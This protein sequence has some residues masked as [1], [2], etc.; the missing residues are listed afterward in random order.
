MTLSCGTIRSPTRVI[1]EI[2]SF[3]S[4]TNPF[5]VQTDDG[6]GF[7]KATNN[8]YNGPALTAELVAA[9]LGTWFGLQI[10]AFAVIPTCDIDLPMKNGQLVQGPLF[11]S[12]EVEATSFD[13]SDLFLKKLH[14]KTDIAK[15]VVFDTWIMNWDRY[16]LGDANAENLLFA[17]RDKSRKYDLIPIDH[18]WAFD[19]DFPLALNEDDV[20]SPGVYGRFPAFEPYITSE[21]LAPALQRLRS[22]D[23]TFVKEVINSV[24]SEWGVGPVARTTLIELICSRAAFVVNTIEE[25]LIDAPLLPGVN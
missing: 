18:T 3:P 14:D 12:A 7:I 4:S 22:L 25:R 5:F 2:K 10:P 16:G 8:P 15:L 11:F 6:R 1:R 21:T 13:G 20:E 19:G 24:P 23:R 17:K 9:E